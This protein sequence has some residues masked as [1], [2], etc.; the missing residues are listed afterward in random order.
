MRETRHLWI[1]NLADNIREERIAEH[2]KRYGKIDKV[3]FLPRRS[4]ETGL[5]ACVAFMDI[6]SAQKAKSGVNVLGDRELITDYFDPAAR[7]S[8]GAAD[9][10]PKHGQQQ[11]QQH[12]TNQ[13]RRYE[14]HRESAVVGEEKPG[15]GDRYSRDRQASYDRSYQTSNIQAGGTENYDSDSRGRIE[16]NIKVKLRSKGSNSSAKASHD[17]SSKKHKA[18]SAKSAKKKSKKMK[19]EDGRQKQT[20]PKK[21]K[22]K[23]AKERG[24]SPTVK[25]KKSANA[26]TSPGGGKKSGKLGAGSSSAGRSSS[27]GSVSMSTSGSGR[28]SSTSSTSSSVSGNSSRT[29]TTTNSGSES[30]YETEGPPTHQKLVAMCIKK[31]PVRPTVTSLRD[32]VFHEFKKYGKVKSV[33][34]RGEGVDRHA[35]VL[36]RTA[37]EANKAV[38]H[39]KTKLLFG[40]AIEASI[41]EGE[42][43][44]QELEEGGG[45]I[46]E[47][48]PRAS[49]T[50][51]VGN[52]D[53]TVGYSDIQNIFIRF[54]EIVAIEIK[55][56]HNIPQYAFLQYTDILSVIRAITKM[57]GEKLGRNT[58]KLGFGK[59]VM[60]SCLWV[61]GV[62]DSFTE[63][64]LASCFQRYGPVKHVVIDRNRGQALVF[65]S[66]FDFA[67]S[68]MAK[69]R[70]RILNGSRLKMD[71][72]SNELIDIFLK[73]MQTSGQSIKGLENIRQLM[74]PA[75]SPPSSSMQ[76]PGSSYSRASVSQDTRQQYYDDRS[77]SSFGDDPYGSTD[78]NYRRGWRGRSR[79]RYQYP[80]DQSSRHGKRS[81]EDS[82]ERQDFYRERSPPAWEHDGYNERR[83][84]VSSHYD[85][86]YRQK[87]YD[88]R[89][90]PRTYNR[91]SARGNVPYDEMF[92]GGYRTSRDRGREG[93]REREIEHVRDRDRVGEQYYNRAAHSSPVHPR[94]VSHRSRSISPQPNVGQRD[95]DT[96]STERTVTYRRRG[97]SGSRSPDLSVDSLRRRNSMESKS[98]SH[99]GSRYTSRTGDIDMRENMSILMEGE[100][101]LSIN[102]PI[103]EVEF[104]EKQKKLRVRKRV[105]E[106]SPV[107]DLSDSSPKPHRRL[108]YKNSASENEKASSSYRNKEDRRIV[109]ETQWAS[110]SPTYSD[111]RSRSGTP[112]RD[113]NQDLIGEVIIKQPSS[114]KSSHRIVEKASRTK[115][116]SKQR[117]GERKDKNKPHDKDYRKGFTASDEIRKFDSAVK[118][119]T[120]RS[121][122]A[123][124][125][126]RVHS[127]SELERKTSAIYTKD[128]DYRK[129][130]VVRSSKSSGDVVSKHSL[131][132]PSKHDEASEKIKRS[133][134]QSHVRSPRA[135]SEYGDE[136]KNSPLS[137]SPASDQPRRRLSGSSKLLKREYSPR[138]DDM[139]EPYSEKYSKTDN[140]K[141]RIVNEKQK[142]LKDRVSSSRSKERDEENIDVDERR[143]YS[144]KR[145]HSAGDSDSE[146]MHTKRDRKSST[147]DHARHKMLSQKHEAPMSIARQMFLQEEDVESGAESPL[148]VKDGKSNVIDEKVERRDE[149]E[150]AEQDQKDENPSEDSPTSDFSSAKLAVAQS[151]LPK[152]LPK[153]VPTK[154]TE[155]TSPAVEEKVEKKQSQDGNLTDLE[156]EKERL[157]QLLSKLDSEKHL[158]VKA[159]AEVADVVLQELTQ[160]AKSKILATKTLKDVSIIKDSVTEKSEKISTEPS[161][162]NDHAQE[163]RQEENE[164]YEDV[165]FEEEVVVDTIEEVMEDEVIESEIEEVSV[166]H[167]EVEDQVENPPENIVSQ[168]VTIDVQVPV[169]VVPVITAP[170]SENIDNSQGYRKQMEAKKKE[171]EHLEKKREHN[172]KKLM[173]K[174][175]KEKKK[176]IKKVSAMRG[177]SQTVISSVDDGEDD[178]ASPEETEDLSNQDETSQ[179]SANITKQD[180]KDTEGISSQ[181]Q[182]SSQ[183][184]ESSNVDCSGENCEPL[185]AKKSKVT[186]P[187]GEDKK[188]TQNLDLQKPWPPDKPGDEK[189]TSA[190]LEQANN[191]NSDINEN[192]EITPNPVDANLQ[193]AVVEDAKNAENSEPV[194]GKTISP[195]TPG[196]VGPSPMVTTPQPVSKDPSPQSAGHGITPGSLASSSLSQKSSRTPA[197]TPSTTRTPNFTTPSPASTSSTSSS[198]SQNKQHQ[199]KN[200]APIS[201]HRQSG[202][203]PS[204]SSKKQSHHSRSDPHARNRGSHSSASDYKRKGGH[205]HHQHRTSSSSHSSKFTSESSKM[206]N[207]I[208]ISRRPMASITVGLDAS[209]SKPLGKSELERLKIELESVKNQLNLEMSPSSL[210]P[211]SEDEAAVGKSPAQLLSPVSPVLRSPAD[212]PVSRKVDTTP[213]ANTQSG[214]SPSSTPTLTDRLKLIGRVKKRTPGSTPSVKNE[215]T[216]VQN[217]NQKPDEIRQSRIFRSNIFDQ[218][219]ERLSHVRRQLEE[220][221]N[222]DQKAIPFSS[223]VPLFA[224]SKFLEQS[225]AV[226]ILS[227]SGSLNIAQSSLSKETNDNSAVSM[228]S[229]SNSLPAPVDVDV[230]SRQL[231]LSS[232]SG[233][234][235]VYSLSSSELPAT[236]ERKAHDF[237]GKNCNIIVENNEDKKHTESDVSQVEVQHLPAFSNDFTN[238][239]VGVRDPSPSM[240]KSEDQTVSDSTSITEAG[241]FA[242]ETIILDIPKPKL[243]LKENE[244]I[245]LNEKSSSILHTNSEV[246][247]V[248]P[249]KVE[250]TEIDQNPKTLAAISSIA[251]QKTEN[252]ETAEK[253]PKFGE[254]SD[255]SVIENENQQQNIATEA[256]VVKDEIPDAL[257]GIV[258]EDGNDDHY[259]G[260]IVGDMDVYAGS[261]ME[262]EETC[263]ELEIAEN[264]DDIVM[265]VSEAGGGE[266]FESEAKIIEDQKNDADLKEPVKSKTEK[267]ELTKDI[268]L[269]EA[270]IIDKPTSTVVEKDETTRKIKSDE[271]IDKEKTEDLSDEKVKTE[272]KV[273]SESKQQK[274]TISKEKVEQSKSF[275]K[276]TSAFKEKVKAKVKHADKTVKIPHDKREQVKDVTK[277]D[278]IVKHK[279]SSESAVSKNTGELKKEN[280]IVGKKDQV[281]N[282]KPK[283]DIIKHKTSKSADTKPKSDVVSAEKAKSDKSKS[284]SHFRKEKDSKIITKTSTFSIEGDKAKVLPPKNQGERSSPK[285]Q[286]Q[287]DIKCL[288]TSSNNPKDV[289]KKNTNLQDVAAVS[290]SKEKERT[291]S[292]EKK[293]V[294]D[295]KKEKKSSS[296]SD[297]LLSSK[298]ESKKSK[299]VNIKVE[300]NDGNPSVGQSCTV[301]V[302]ENVKPKIIGDNI[303][304]M[305]QE[306]KTAKDKTVT[307]SR[308]DCEKQTTKPIPH[309]SKKQQDKIQNENP[310]SEPRIT[311]IKE[312]VENISSKK[313]K[314]KKKQSDKDVTANEKGKLTRKIS[315]DRSKSKPESSNYEKSDKRD[316][317]IAEK[318]K[319]LSKSISN[320]SKLSSESKSL[321]VEVLSEKSGSHGDR[322]KS[323]SHKKE[324][325]SDK[326][327]S[328]D[329]SKKK[330]I[331]PHDDLK[332]SHSLP[333][334][335]LKDVSGTKKSSSKQVS[336]LKTTG[337]AS[338]ASPASISQSRYSMIYDSS[339]SDSEMSP[340]NPPSKKKKVRNE[341]EVEESKNL[342]KSESV[343][344][345]KNK[346]NEKSGPKR[347]NWSTSSMSSCS[348]IDAGAPPPILP[349][350]SLVTETI[351]NETI[352][353]PGY[354]DDDADDRYSD[355]DDKMAE[356]LNV[357]T[358]EKSDS[359]REMS[360]ILGGKIKKKTT[361][362]KKDSNTKTP[363]NA[364]RRLIVTSSDS[365]SSDQELVIS[366]SSTDDS[367]DEIGSMSAWAKVDADAAKAET[368]EK[369]TPQTGKSEYGLDLS[370]DSDSTGEEFPVVAKT[371]EKKKIE[372]NKVS[373]KLSKKPEILKKKTSKSGMSKSKTKKDLFSDNS[374]T[375]SEA[376][377]RDSNKKTLTKPS[378]DSKKG[379]DVGLTPSG[380]KLSE[381]AKNVKAKP[382]VTKTE[383]V[384]YKSDIEFSSSSDSDDFDAVFTSKQSEKKKDVVEIPPKLKDSSGSKSS[385]AIIDKTKSDSKLAK[386]SFKS[387]DKKEKLKVKSASVEKLPSTDKLKDNSSK[388]HG[389]KTLQKIQHHGTSRSPAKE[390]TKTV[391]ESTSVVD[392]SKHE[393]KVSSSSKKEHSHKSKHSGSKNVPTTKSHTS[394]GS[395]KTPHKSTGEG[396]LQK[397]S[398]KSSKTDDKKILDTKPLESEVFVKDPKLH[399][400]P[401]IES[402]NNDA[403]ENPDV[404]KHHK[405]KKMKKAHKLEEKSNAE[406]QHKEKK[407]TELSGK[408]SA[409]KE[410]RI[411]KDKLTIPSASQSQMITSKLSEMEQKALARSLFNSDSDDDDDENIIDDV[412]ENFPLSTSKQH[413]KDTISTD[414]KSPK[415]KVKEEIALGDTSHTKEKGHK[416]ESNYQKSKTSLTKMP[417]LHPLHSHRLSSPKSSEKRRGSAESFLTTSTTDESDLEQRMAVQSAISSLDHDDDMAI[418]PDLVDIKQESGNHE[419]EDDNLPPPFVSKTMFEKDQKSEMGFDVMSST[420]KNLASSPSKSS[421]VKSESA[422]PIHS[423]EKKKKSKKDKSHRERRGHKS[424][425]PHVPGFS[426]SKHGLPFSG[427][428]RREHIDKLKSSSHERD[429]EAV[430]SIMG[431]LD[432]SS[433]A[434]SYFSDVR[435][436]DS[437]SHASVLGNQTP[438]SDRGRRRSLDSDASTGRNKSSTAPVVASDAS[439]ETLHEVEPKPEVVQT[440][441]NVKVEDSTDV[442]DTR[443]T[444]EENELAAAVS[445]I[446]ALFGDF[447]N[448]P[449]TF[450]D[451]SSAGSSAGYNEQQVAQD[452]VLEPESKSNS[453]EEKDLSQED[454]DRGS[455]EAAMAASTLLMETNEEDN[456]PYFGY[457]DFQ[458]QKPLSE[459]SSNRKTSTESRYS[460]DAFVRRS[461]KEMDIE[462]PSIRTDTGVTPATV[463]DQIADQL[464]SSGQSKPSRKR[465]RQTKSATS[466]V[467]SS[468]LESKSDLTMSDASAS[469]SELLLHETGNSDI[470]RHGKGAK[471]RKIGGSPSH[472]QSGNSNKSDSYDF[473]AS[474]KTQSLSLPKPE[475]TIGTL[476]FVPSSNTTTFSHLVPS[477][478]TSSIPV[479]S[480]PPAPFVTVSSTP[481]TAGIRSSS[482]EKSPLDIKPPSVLPTHQPRRTSYDIES[483]NIAVG[484]AKRRASTSSSTAPSPTHGGSQFTQLTSSASSFGGMHMPGSSVYL[485]NNSAFLPQNPTVI[486][487]PTITQPSPTIT[488]SN[489]NPATLS[490]HQTS[491]RFFHP[492]GQVFP[493]AH[494]TSPRAGHP[495]TTMHSMIPS[496]VQLSQPQVYYPHIS[497]GHSAYMTTTMRPMVSYANLRHTSPTSA[498]GIQAPLQ[499]VPRHTHPPPQ[500]NASSHT[501]LTSMPSHFPNTSIV[502]SIG[503]Q[504]V[505][506]NNT[507]SSTSYSPAL[508]L[509]SATAAASLTTPSSRQHQAPQAVQQR[510][511][512]TSQTAQHHVGVPT[513]PHAHHVRPHQP[514]VSTQAS[515]PQNIVTATRTDTTPKSLPRPQLIPQ[516]MFPH[517][518]PLPTQISPKGFPQQPFPILSP[519][520]HSAAQISPSSAIPPTTPQTQDKSRAGI[521]R[522]PSDPYLIK[523]NVPPQSTQTVSLASPHIKITET[524]GQVVTEKTEAP[525]P[526]PPSPAVPNTSQPVM[527]Q[528]P[529]QM[530]AHHPHMYYPQGLHTLPGGFP[531][532]PYM[533]QPFILRPGIPPPT[534]VMHPAAAQLPDIRHSQQ[535]MMSQ[536]QRLQLDKPQMQVTT[537]QQQPLSHSQT[538]LRKEQKIPQTE[539]TKSSPTM[540]DPPHSLRPPFAIHQAGPPPQLH[541][542]TQATSHPSYGPPFT[543]SPVHRS[544]RGERIVRMPSEISQIDMV[545]QH[546]RQSGIPTTPPR[547]SVPSTNYQPQT[548]KPRQLVPPKQEHA[549]VPQSLPHHVLY[550][551]SVFQR[552]GLGMPHPHGFRLPA[553]IRYPTS[554]ADTMWLRP[555]AN[556]RPPTVPPNL[557]QQQH[558]LY[559]SAAEANRPTPH[560]TPARSPHPRLPSSQA[561]QS[562]PPPSTT[563]KP[564]S[565]APPNDQVMDLFQ[566][567]PVIWQGLLALRNDSA[568]VQ[569]HF[570]CGDLGL[571]QAC[572]PKPDASQTETDRERNLAVLRIVQRMRLEPPQLEGVDK[573]MTANSDFCLLLAL[574]C[575]RDKTDVIRQQNALKQGFIDY[576]KQKQAAGIV[577]VKH[578]QPQ[579]QVQYVLHVFP[580]CDFTTKHLQDHARDLLSNI[581]DIQHI[582]IVIAAV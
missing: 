163:I 165:T 208:P 303:E 319:M 466:S 33:L 538:P 400:K 150:T 504:P 219:S 152:R 162:S 550:P 369:K 551:Q 187:S 559:V 536:Q 487:D 256:D 308:T 309:D 339:S 4:G 269:P 154:E 556:F 272:T 332:V 297:K 217:S 318:V 169:P 566:R 408:E 229:T 274:E 264:D 252:V 407:T 29:R 406:S 111:N 312:P 168:P 410:Q 516:G 468:S 251:P 159:A 528:M 417:S 462:L 425:K 353:P 133:K 15:Y 215:V 263:A 62:T 222:A 394:D 398:K 543:A 508:S 300:T 213:L 191:P 548:D 540:R 83:T 68:A 46:D 571:A 35:L 495:S 552:P 9:E 19:D 347:M 488:Q 227:S 142:H 514:P 493:Q 210:S 424:L 21:I 486:G 53:K 183:G 3:R 313:K 359:A 174:Q 443:T 416:H 489:M 34:I 171:S 1:G 456:T 458:N 175:E 127:P 557:A 12:R 542:S 193:T 117:S 480:I 138:P 14:A 181:D 11:Q 299:K 147:G 491:P 452:Q 475:T 81:Y 358:E 391:K 413:G 239:N 483:S 45:I 23:H 197:T 565:S 500:P 280:P 126:Q 324:G 371:S 249:V 75:S 383:K 60:S 393:T 365:D 194:P 384:K 379:K 296:S 576:L 155:K 572:L 244:N 378:K 330:S 178:T 441:E 91:K 235:N 236:A 32:G 281:G 524:T 55:K 581:N 562:T 6:R 176:H 517:G 216:P 265:D 377:K 105:I 368:E 28:T 496:S 82:Y 195:L 302:S 58:L 357:K 199:T 267:S 259:L 459:N 238:S 328:S 279:M 63:N 316:P 125:I 225:P 485:Y 343:R 403:S 112:T 182:A 200:A 290:K 30:S 135:S 184:V 218:D 115:E 43:S 499:F 242:E 333:D 94:Y 206:K 484:Q 106:E 447:D 254:K 26:S 523:P 422:K 451:F 61:D 563:P 186:E 519:T 69:M 273:E 209:P 530:F 473:D 545:D 338:S 531:G 521:Q 79:D 291:S 293:T 372:S 494:L 390:K 522:Q 20:G 224:G 546:F 301:L 429:E 172:R 525:R 101:K 292:K 10:A 198:K 189:V 373:K 322:I 234:K 431:I 428:D 241:D 148:H 374:D 136:A 350:S 498:Q 507:H 160:K 436:E 399:Q 389:D 137:N 246:L 382:L 89:R 397:H 262:I 179:E 18:D 346:S 149:S 190:S 461:S 116:D 549:N 366:M 228:L 270:K 78:P 278:K 467:R 57:D 380:S 305:K 553:G 420:E 220:E 518:Y 260:E 533:A 349:C 386:R 141:T 568:A 472:I 8:S 248:E 392:S 232:L 415:K 276:G 204:H 108:G 577:N 433:D 409:D 76:G 72:A 285:K 123:S 325:T 157:Q 164:T 323:K 503:Q 474:L 161:S 532:L 554:Q 340:A 243:E 257:S 104:N 341:S 282:K 124:L 177:P 97:R 529:P 130:S 360:P 515:I 207:I 203:V 31:L 226:N 356:E 402:K 298:S 42:V 430:R 469:E 100:D 404:H 188:D 315:E 102:S 345:D 67:Q 107:R 427:K 470:V 337:K 122:S 561:P 580:P 444:A 348:S 146:E 70:A 289:T 2:F 52:L 334:K 381:S 48:H 38:S 129:H 367:D 537:A 320:K 317:N 237:A 47:F 192:K 13:T 395:S 286:Q 119:K 66:Q 327:S 426:L 134:L 477:T 439:F 250:M 505:S 173:R 110:E 201:S 170:K 506:T 17:P 80:P 294:K 573:R 131:K 310:S 437:S 432:E 558:S 140:E 151:L 86:D 555:G 74:Q 306:P 271:N 268:L 513:Y 44:G 16:G 22:Q 196:S 396:V 440:T 240:L 354:D 449:S 212:M 455:D 288:S 103:G 490:P 283:H 560:L 476:P 233:P 167:E 59:T 419:E 326:V 255:S 25:R 438:D 335:S 547:A 361:Q 418:S 445:S 153:S 24:R 275:E 90:E 464:P 411:E 385:K 7:S 460:D 87:D 435:P 509:Y 40:A 128:F 118:G 284:K 121:N 582:M 56:Q 578:A 95:A 564:A 166:I 375:D 446:E 471:Q 497:Q 202:Q 344:D 85:Q 258:T 329:I 574:P 502:G 84:T 352:L 575:G 41:Y 114:S 132:I 511:P 143:S 442:I 49:R 231:P 96:Y 295:I 5:S 277:S 304:E 180:E 510:I 421:H 221:K 92:Q 355:K 36:F 65:Y 64:Y 453:K 541:P 214:V 412:T 569:T 457:R 185:D 492:A 93:D 50:L 51:F 535:K 481:P 205:H 307:V 120:G 211:C 478:T 245:A 434:D 450:E 253:D 479:S 27:S 567:Y 98:S 71:Y 362:L 139:L 423:T 266:E 99:S 512:E 482:T 579:N 261:C 376:E 454:L 314:K 570:I 526:Q 534:S 388:S 145:R 331:K 336:N 109:E 520:R 144:Q 465:Q 527:S 230:A 158:D 363:D 387:D 501:N 364:I 351:K 401:K 113:E 414:R 287:T 54:G 247:D 77:Q 405:K 156:K 88:I 370:S 311:S 448:K 463:S 223:G 39:A 321:S 73:H 342:Q 539:A 544:E 37:A